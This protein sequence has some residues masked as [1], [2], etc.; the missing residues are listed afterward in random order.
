MSFVAAGAAPAPAVVYELFL[1]GYSSSIGPHSCSVDKS[2]QGICSFIQHVFLE[3]VWVETKL[4][5]EAYMKR[6]LVLTTLLTTQ[7]ERP[8]QSSFPPKENLSVNVF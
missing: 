8:F 2:A 4:L 7:P 6:C 5:K 1:R 3:K